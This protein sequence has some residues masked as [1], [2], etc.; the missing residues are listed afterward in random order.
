MSPQRSSQS[1]KTTVAPDMD[2]ETSDPPMRSHGSSFAL[3]MIMELK[4]AQGGISNSVIGLTRSIELHG[5]KLDSIADLRADIREITTKLISIDSSQ[6]D[7]KDKLDHVRTFV[8]GATA[9]IAC[10]VI[11]AQLALRFWPSTSQVPPQIIVNVPASPQ[12]TGPQSLVPSQPA[13]TPTPSPIVPA[14]P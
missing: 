12:Q 7:L 10:L 5:T 3:Q 8:I 11:V 9:V 6:K 13:P 14:K 2:F 4:G 1:D